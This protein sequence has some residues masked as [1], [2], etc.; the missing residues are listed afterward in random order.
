MS[1]MSLQCA[2]SQVCHQ[3]RPKVEVN[4][5]LQPATHMNARYACRRRNK[6]NGTCF[7]AFPRPAMSQLKPSSHPG[8]PKL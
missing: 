8:S 5:P 1:H 4:L 6:S 7:G 3:K 2:T